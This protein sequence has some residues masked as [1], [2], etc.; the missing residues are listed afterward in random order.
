M[1]FEEMEKLRDRL[2]TMNLASTTWIISDN[3][4]GNYKLCANRD[5]FEVGIDVPGYSS[6]KLSDLADRLSIELPRHRSTEKK[7]KGLY[8]YLRDVRLILEKAK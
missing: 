7:L 3:G 5:D 8:E 2:N 6:V 1:T 4:W